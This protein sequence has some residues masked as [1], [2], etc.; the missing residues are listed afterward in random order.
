MIAK[1][2]GRCDG[3]PFPGL[4][5]FASDDRQF[6][7]G[8]EEEIYALYRLLDQ[9]RFVAV[10]G[11]PSSGKAS[12]VNAGLLPLLTVEAESGT[13]R[14]WRLL[15]ISTAGSPLDG[16]TDGLATGLL[17]RNFEEFAAL[18]ERIKWCLSSSSFGIVEALK[19]VGADKE[20][21]FVL[22]LR[23]F[24][25]ASRRRFPVDEGRLADEA[26]QFVQLLLEASR[27]E[28]FDV[29]VLITMRADFFGECAFF[30]G[31]PDAV[32]AGQF[33]V[34][35]LQR[36]GIEEAIVRPIAVAGGS[37]EPALVQTLCNHYGTKFDELPVLQHCLR[38]LWDRAAAK[39]APAPPHLTLEHYDAIGRLDGALSLHAD[40]IMA[41]LKGL[42]PAVELTFRALAD[43]DRDGRA[44]RRP[45]TF[46]QLVAETGLREHDLR[47]V[48]DRFRSD[49]CAFLVP[50]LSV[51]PELAPDFVIDIGHEVLLHRWLRLSGDSEV[52]GWVRSE[53][54]DGRR[55]RALLTLAIDDGAKHSLLSPS[56]ADDY[57]TWWSSSPRTS[58]WAARYG[59][60]IDRV[61]DY[62]EES[63]AAAAASAAAM[64]RRVV[65]LRRLVWL[66]GGGAVVLILVEAAIIAKYAIF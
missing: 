35:S 23:A 18:Q 5:S 14:K 45:L 66:L 42:E 60:E 8:R 22:I 61:V 28:N 1:S 34:P 64:Q 15:P 27:T 51:V 58:A 59:G 10:V 48:V 37:I 62:L 63:R 65:G 13:G 38:R 12:L 31:L 29:S 53:E 21:S 3:N 26:I 32:A 19:S 4:R 44:I 46:T 52:A 25:S 16:L 40:E 17:G 33:F 30:Q 36:Q 11:A 55:Y 7:F 49:D 50:T 56:Q 24:E 43:Q 6:F 2:F 9:S 54:A 20:E 41:S 57:W 39:A 47:H